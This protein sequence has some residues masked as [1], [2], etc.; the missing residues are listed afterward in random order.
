M[1]S[2]IILSA[3]SAN[4]F[5]STCTAGGAVPELGLDFELGS[6]ELLGEEDPLFDVDL[7]GGGAA[8]F[9]LALWCSLSC[10]D[11]SGLSCSRAKHTIGKPNLS[12]ENSLCE[13]L[14]DLGIYEFLNLFFRNTAIA[15]SPLQELLVWHLK[16][17]HI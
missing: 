5:W 17:R 14:K 10:I 16:Q 6:K 12:D 9:C 11:F 15:S 1:S 3:A 4:F 7:C 2:A 8:V 13:I